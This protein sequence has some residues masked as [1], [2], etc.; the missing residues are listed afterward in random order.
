MP[1]NSLNVS[2]KGADDIFSTEESRQEQQ[3]EQ[4]QQISIEEL[5]PFKNHPFKVLD[6]ESMQRTVES[7]EQYGVLSPLIARPRPEGGYEI[8]SG[9]RRQHAAQ[10][11]GLDT[12][13]VIVRQMDDDA[14]V[15]LMVDSNLQRENILP[16]ERA[17]AYKMKLEAIDRTVGRPKNLG[18]VVPDYFGKRS[19]EIVAEGTGESYKQV[20]RFIRLTNLI[21][22]LLDMVDEKKI[23]FNPAVELSHLDTNQ[24]RDFL[25]AMNDTQNAPSLSQAQRLKKLA[26]EGHFSY[27]VAFA[28]MGEEKKDELDKVVIKND[29]LRKYFPR[30]YTPKQ[31][32]DTIIKLLDQWQ[33]MVYDDKKA[34]GE[35]LLLARQEMPNADMMLLGTYRGFELNIRFDSFKNEHQA[36]LRAELSY[37]VSLGDD[38]RGN[39][40]RLD[41]A[42]DNF[43]DRIADAENALQNLEQQKQAAEVEVAKP[44]AQE[45]ELA[46]K[47]ARL[48]ELNALLNIDRDRS[49]SQDAPEETE[50]TETP[51]TRP[52]VLAALGEKTNQPEPVKPFKSYLDKEG[53]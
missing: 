1:K 39:I 20:Q 27:D 47:S 36:V 3:R 21:P 15:L 31:M 10:L 30:S 18:Q 43:A 45:E 46:E 53:R 32:E 4:V 44:F 2:L 6:D 25:E 38:A 48:A 33:R 13:P 16:S 19:T 5:F 37:P 23:A 22:E 11:A 7:V 28:V 12:L 40:T 51:A 24:Q 41:N 35:R 42:I 29:T 50:E 52:S 17:F 49:S 8:I 26:Q 14:A 9:H 34:A